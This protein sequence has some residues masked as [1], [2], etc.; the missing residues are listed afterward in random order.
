MQTTDLS[1][2]TNRSRTTM[3][4]LALMTTAALA[5]VVGLLGGLVAALAGT[6]IAGSIA[7]GC[8]AFA[9]SMMIGLAI[10]KLVMR[11]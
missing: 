10:I 2:G 11:R 1:E 3:V 6:P 5:A 9:A 7:A 8:S 4:V